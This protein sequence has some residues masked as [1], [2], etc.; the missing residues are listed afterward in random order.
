LSNTHKRKRITIAPLVTP[1]QSPLPAKSLSVDCDLDAPSP[2]SVMLNEPDEESESED[3]DLADDYIHRDFVTAKALAQRRSERTR[4]PISY[5]GCD[6]DVPKRPVRGKAK[7]AGTRAKAKLRSDK[8]KA[9]APCSTPKKSRRGFGS[10]SRNSNGKCECPFQIVCPTLF[11]RFSDVVRHLESNVLHT[12]TEKD[13]WECQNCGIRLARFD[14]YKRHVSARACGKRAPTKKVRPV[15]P[16]EVERELEHIRNSDH[17]AIL[18]AK[19]R[20]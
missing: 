8:Y 10:S 13:C 14:S 6:D 16:P 17:P 9:Q 5:V 11:G 1:L 2:S 18:A 7:S 19:Q 4:A 3:A 15:Y 12:H 20:L